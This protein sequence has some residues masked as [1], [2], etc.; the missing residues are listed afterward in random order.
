MSDDIFNLDEFVSQEPVVKK[1]SA[2]EEVCKL[3]VY[4]C[5]H[6]A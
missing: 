4:L 1:A 6:W 2:V 5:G 3:Y